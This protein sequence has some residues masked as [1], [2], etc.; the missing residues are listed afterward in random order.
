VH[1]HLL[2]RCRS[3]VHPERP[4]FSRQLGPGLRKKH[5]WQQAVSVRHIHWSVSAWCLRPVTA[6]AHASPACK[7]DPQARDE[8]PACQMGSG[9]PGILGRPGTDCG[10]AC[11]EIDGNGRQRPCGSRPARMSLAAGL[12][13]SGWSPGGGLWST[14]G[15]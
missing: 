14:C 9:L 5:H 8:P 1:V 11:C 4:C 2:S 3:R 15:R 13:G 6:L 12:S 7:S 10:R